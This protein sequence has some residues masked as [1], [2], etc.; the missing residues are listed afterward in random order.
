MPFKLCGSLF[1][2]HPQPLIALAP[3]SAFQWGKNRIRLSKPESLGYQLFAPDA[4]IVAALVPDPMVR[5][6]AG[7]TVYI[8][9]PRGADIKGNVWAPRGT[10]MACICVPFKVHLLMKVLDA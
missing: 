1:E 9:W 3:R 2:G 4:H 8:N 6:V 10:E 7:G 5:V